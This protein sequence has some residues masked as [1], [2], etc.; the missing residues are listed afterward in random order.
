LSAVRVIDI[1]SDSVVEIV[2]RE[3]GG[4]GV[5]CVLD[6]QDFE[7]DDAASNADTYVFAMSFERLRT[8]ALHLCC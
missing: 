7:L 3:T 8:A 5:D 1:S 2:L 6:L 4:V